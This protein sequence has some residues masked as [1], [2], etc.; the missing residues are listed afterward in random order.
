MVYRPAPRTKASS[1][2]PCTSARDPQ[3][4]IFV[5][6]PRQWERFDST[7]VIAKVQVYF[8]EYLK[9]CHAPRKLGEL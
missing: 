5:K 9:P 3:P 1:L 7:T 4:G 6:V 8:I 2:I